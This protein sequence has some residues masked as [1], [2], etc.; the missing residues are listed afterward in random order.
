MITCFLKYEVDA[1]SLGDFEKYAKMWL[2]LIAK[3]GGTHHG[4]FLPSEGASDIAYAMFSFPSLAVYEE[5]RQKSA[6]D[7]ECQSAIEFYK[8]T[9]CFRRYE[10]SFLRPVLE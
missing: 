5:Y 2:P 4:Y 6:T 1:E 9:K 10:R 3:F 8:Q 7:E